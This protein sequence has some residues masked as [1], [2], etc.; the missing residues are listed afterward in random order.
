MWST[1]AKAP[2]SLRGGRKW[3]VTRVSGEDS[4]TLEE[5]ELSV[6]SKK[7]LVLIARHFLHD[8]AEGFLCGLKATH[9]RASS[10]FVI[11]GR[12]SM[13]Y[14]GK[15][16]TVCCCI[17]NTCDD[18]AEIAAAKLYL[19]LRGIFFKFLST[20][21]NLCVEDNDINWLI[22]LTCPLSVIDNILGLN[23]RHKLDFPVIGS[24]TVRNLSL[25][26]D[27]SL[28]WSLTVIH[29]GHNSPITRHCHY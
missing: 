19:S 8:L 27:I 24:T 6:S 4:S 10:V 21:N 20:R 5:E 28:V 26:C 23:F 1:G 11:S 18:V 17:Q 16:K 13:W 9:R 12:S 15:M 25:L 2:E 3:I 22:C 14:S 29:Q 7:L